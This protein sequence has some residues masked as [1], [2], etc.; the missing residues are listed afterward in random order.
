MEKINIYLAGGMKS[1][2]QDI[3]IDNFRS[4]RFIHLNFYDPR[5]HGLES[6]DAYTV[7]DL[8]AIQSC[9]WVFAY[10]EADNPSGIGMALEI[11]YAYA[12]KKNIIFVDE[13]ATTD[14]SR[15]FGMCRVVST[16]VFSLNEGMNTLEKLI[17]LQERVNN[18]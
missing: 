8:A 1:G 9:E 10:M 18:V 14:R 7:W 2:W 4:D 11:G 12:H 3:V 5:S 13:T 15:Y 6:E 17:R 16:T